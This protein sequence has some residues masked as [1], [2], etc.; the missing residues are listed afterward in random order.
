[1]N[2]AN[3]LISDAWGD[4]SPEALERGIG[5]RE[6]ALL[7]LS[8]E[9][10]KLGHKVTNFVNIEAPKRFNEGDGYHEYLPLDGT[11]AILTYLPYDAVVAWECPSLFNDEEIKNNVGIKICEMQ[12][13]HLSPN[14]TKALEKHIDYLAV[15]SDWHGNLILNTGVNFP[16]ENVVTLPNGVDISR[17]PKEAFTAK[18]NKKITPEVKFMYSSSPDRGLWYLLQMWPYLREEYPKAELLV[19]YGA[20]KWINH[21]KW[22]HSRIGEMAVELESLLK[23]PGVKD[24]GKIGQDVLSKLQQ[25]SDAWIYPLDSIQSTETGCIS[26]IENAAAGNPIITSDAD[27]MEEEFSEVGVI[28]DLPFEPQKFAEKSIEVLN[29]QDYVEY[30][31]ETARVFAESRDWEVIAKKWLPTLSGQN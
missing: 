10:A 25:E 9:W 6:G 2:I 26:A 8:R 28:V 31:R 17:Y 14:E 4:V 12:V 27:C 16:K 19:C 22:A 1:M 13:A 29:D 18:I 11:K 24:L 7:Y 23:Q 30:L 20:E 15:L 3:V 5:G 21:I